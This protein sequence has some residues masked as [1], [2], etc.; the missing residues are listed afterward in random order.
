MK[1]CSQCGRVGCPGPNIECAKYRRDPM[2][3]AVSYV[4]VA[5]AAMGIGAAVFALISLIH[6]HWP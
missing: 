4:M 1:R 6:K 2:K 3:Y 5:L